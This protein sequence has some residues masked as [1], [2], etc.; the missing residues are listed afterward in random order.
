MSLALFSAMNL[1]QRVLFSLCSLL[2]YRVEHSKRNST[3]PHYYLFSFLLLISVCSSD[4]Q[5][6]N[7]QSLLFVSD[8]GR[9][10]RAKMWLN[11]LVAVAHTK[12][13]YMQRFFASVDSYLEAAPPS[14]NTHKTMRNVPLFHCSDING[15]II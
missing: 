15:T 9:T 10:N 4:S 14:I 5:E 6:F 3:P 13:A 2:R 12:Q 7:A 11:R 1:C 8:E